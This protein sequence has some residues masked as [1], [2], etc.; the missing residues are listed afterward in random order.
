MITATSRFSY[1]SSTREWRIYAD[2]T[3]VQCDRVGCEATTHPSGLEYN[4]PHVESIYGCDGWYLGPTD[5]CPEHAPKSL[6]E[7]CVAA[8][9]GQHD[10]GVDYDGDYTCSL[11]GLYRAV[12]EDHE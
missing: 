4:G 2:T 1:R 6:D 5:L 7:P 9:N 12:T 11:C 8:E 3:T 10:A